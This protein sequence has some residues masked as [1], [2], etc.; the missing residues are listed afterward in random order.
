V[1]TNNMNTAPAGC[2]YH[3]QARTRMFE[4]I[5][6][7]NDTD[8]EI[9][10]AK[11]DRCEERRAI[12]RHN[13]AQ[14]AARCEFAKLNGWRCTTSWYGFETEVCRRWQYDHSIIDHPLL[15][16][17]IA[18]PYRPVAIVTQPYNTKPEQ[19]KPIRGKL[20]A[21]IETELVWHVPPV[22]LAS[23]HYP[24]ATFFYVLT[25]PGVTVQWLPEQQ[26]ASAS[27][28]GTISPRGT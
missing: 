24:G 14:R 26:G 21:P 28:L 18:R 22:P 6:R 1:G 20:G 19:L 3:I 25:R 5:A 8:E 2:R 9:Q 15:F 17:E 4:L 7:I 13:E 16:R 11:H 23:I 10:A 27:S 12:L